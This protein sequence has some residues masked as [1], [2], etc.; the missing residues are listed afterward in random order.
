MTADEARRRVDT[1]LK[2]AIDIAIRAN[3]AVKIMEAQ[4]A[5]I[6]SLLAELRDTTQSNGIKQRCEAIIGERQP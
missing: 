4:A 3:E 1:K 5:D 6:R 2:V